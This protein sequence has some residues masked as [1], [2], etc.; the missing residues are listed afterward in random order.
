M[1]KQL[2]EITLEDRNKGSISEKS[3]LYREAEIAYMNS[4]EQSEGAGEA[5]AQQAV[6]KVL[7]SYL[8]KCKTEQDFIMFLGTVLVI[9][10]SNP[11]PTPKKE[12]KTHQIVDKLLQVGLLARINFY[13]D[14]SMKEARRVSNRKKMALIV[15]GLGALIAV[16]S[17][18]GLQSNWQDALREAFTQDIPKIDLNVWHIVLMG[19]GVITLSALTYYV[20][21]KSSIEAAKE[22]SYKYLKV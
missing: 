3:S 13:K 2:E 14:A 19:V 21:Q 11:E 9:K 16:A 15:L 20:K 6:T 22:E 10:S 12:K 7:N 8:N 4:L 18:I 1:A 5:E 17:S